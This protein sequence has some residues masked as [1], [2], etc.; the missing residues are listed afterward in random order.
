MQRVDLF[1]EIILKRLKITKRLN[2][3][4]CAN[5][6]IFDSNQVKYGLCIKIVRIEVNCWVASLANSGGHLYNLGGKSNAPILFEQSLST[7]PK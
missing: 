6:V 1:N 7:P 4:L 5:L 2:N 3:H